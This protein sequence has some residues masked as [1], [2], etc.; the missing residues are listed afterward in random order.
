METGLKLRKSSSTCYLKW[1]QTTFFGLTLSL[2]CITRLNSVI[3]VNKMTP[4]AAKLVSNKPCFYYEDMGFAEKC[5]LCTLCPDWLV[6]AALLSDTKHSCLRFW[7]ASAIDRASAS[8]T[9][10]WLTLELRRTTLP[11]C[12][13]PCNRFISVQTGLKRGGATT[14]GIKYELVQMAAANLFPS[15]SLGTANANLLPR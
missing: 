10:S 9:I 13:F 7:L 15:E 6:Y 2:W 12:N 1:N 14:N 3:V 11:R 4:L 5:T 8:D